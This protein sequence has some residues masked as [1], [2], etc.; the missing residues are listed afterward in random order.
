MLKKLLPRYRGWRAGTT[1][2]TVQVATSR[3]RIRLLLGDA[4]GLWAI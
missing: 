4:P 2:C 1:V 3:S